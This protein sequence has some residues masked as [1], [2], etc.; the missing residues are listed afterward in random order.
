M[1]SAMIT[2][3][4]GLAAL[5]LNNASIMQIRLK[6]FFI[7]KSV[8]ALLSEKENQIAQLSALQ[9]RSEP[10]RHGAANLSL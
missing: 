3:K 7:T 10:S 2:T 6:V 8:A 1:T 4:F 9:A 5:A